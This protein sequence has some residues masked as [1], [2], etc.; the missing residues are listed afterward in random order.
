[1][2]LLALRAVASLRKALKGALPHR[3]RGRQPAGQTRK[4]QREARRIEAI[5][6][7]VKALF[8]H[9]T[10]FVQRNLTPAERKTLQK[11]TRGHPELRAL[12]EFVEL[13]YNLFDRRCTTATAQNKL[14]RLRHAKLFSRFPSLLPLLRKLKG[15]NLEKALEFLDD[16]LLEATSNAAERANRRFR[17]IQKTVYRFRCRRMIEAR[18]AIDMLLNFQIRTRGSPCLFPPSGK[19][20]RRAAA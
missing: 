7:Q 11:L 14:Q 1:M 3:S 9:R 19:R 4:Q 5:R 6:E 20:S 16:T 17:K 10:L 2:N 13:I 12:R 15:P 18:I 8:D